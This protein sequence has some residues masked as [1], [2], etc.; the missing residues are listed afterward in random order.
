MV[1]KL[2]NTLVFFKGCHQPRVEGEEIGF[3]EPWL[4]E[5]RGGTLGRYFIDNGRGAISAH[6]LIAMETLESKIKPKSLFF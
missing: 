3:E 5:C 4:I 1:C 2:A 6:P